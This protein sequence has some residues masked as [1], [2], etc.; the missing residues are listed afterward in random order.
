[1]HESPPPVPQDVSVRPT[2]RVRFFVF[3]VIAVLAVTLVALAALLLVRIG[4]IGF[5]DRAMASFVL[6]DTVI[7]ERSYE[8][9]APSRFGL[10]GLKPIELSGV[11]GVSDYARAKGTEAVIAKDAEGVP[12]V[13]LLNREN[14]ALTGSPAAKASLAV[15]PDGKY[16]AYASR[17]DGE[18][19]YTPELSAWSMQVISIADG[20][21]ATLGT[22]FAP[23]FF[24][25]DDATWLLYTSADAITV[26]KVEEGSF[27]AFST[28]FE[29]NDDVWFAAKASPDGQYL[30]LR[31]AATRQFSLYGIRRA[32]A[33]L[34]LGLDPL[35]T[36]LVGLYDVAFAGGSVYGID[37]FDA[38]IEGGVAVLKV[39][40]SSDVEGKSVYLFP[41]SGNYRLIP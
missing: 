30:A 25:R 5:Y 16:I 14:V 6:R 24:T 20:S 31:D 22:G 32:T 2:S 27:V 23:S 40:P 11:T 26:T 10:S 28:P 39:D 34:P 19:E 36:D 38:G 35:T 4:G 12:Q 9:V 1:M 29:I 41:A 8:S 37:A 13:F 15:S 21:V 18:S 33:D 17:T 7:A 3:A